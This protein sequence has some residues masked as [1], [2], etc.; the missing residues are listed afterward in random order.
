VAPV[1][2]TPGLWRRFS[3]YSAVSHLLNLSDYFVSWMFAV[4]L[5]DN[6]AQIAIYTTGSTIVRQAMAL[7]YRPLVGIQVPLF[8]RVKGG[9]STLPEAYAAVGRILA[10]IMIPGG[11]GLVILARELILVQYPAV[12]A[13]AAL[14]IA[15]LTPCL[16][17]ESFLSSAQIVLQVYERYRLL[18][19]S[20]ASIVLV[21][22][23]MW[24]A[25]DYG[26]VGVALVLGLGRLLFGLT[27][28]V[29]AWRVL[30]LR[31]S[32]GF[33]GRVT[34]AALAMAAVVLGLEWALGLHH[35][36][37]EVSARLLA[38]AQLV[39]II[40]AGVLTFGVA[41]RLLGGI[42]PDDRRWIAESSLP[43]KKWIVRLL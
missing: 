43:L 38:A 10:L 29:L 27:A 11:V 8:T 19:I 4:L 39:G 1:A 15:I 22:P 25:P 42:E 14:V 6:L 37:R 9:E 26:L 18:L 34:L 21:V 40:G 16:F 20:R 30:P 41:L 32:W 7:L 24:F 12:Y 23:L 36:G 31:Y 13:E 5:L 28:V 33:F 17:L 2:R 3:L 35:I